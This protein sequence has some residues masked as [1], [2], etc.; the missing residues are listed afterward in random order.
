RTLI[1][2]L[3][4]PFDCHVGIDLCEALENSFAIACTLSGASRIPFFSIFVLNGCAE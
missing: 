2:D 3:S 4:P 1:I